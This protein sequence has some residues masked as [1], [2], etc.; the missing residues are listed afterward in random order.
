MRSIDTRL[1]RLEAVCTPTLDYWQQRAYEYAVE[2]LG[3]PWAAR[4][5]PPIR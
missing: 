3:E 5:F 2:H 1:H 4:L